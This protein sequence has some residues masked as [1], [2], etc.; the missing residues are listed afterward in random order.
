MGPFIDES[1]SKS[2]NQLARAISRPKLL[3]N[4]CRTYCGFPIIDA[5]TAVSEL[6][7]LLSQYR[8]N[9]AFFLGQ[10]PSFS[11]LLQP[12]GE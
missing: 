12:R 11:P 5:S 10:A 3:P 7:H 6:L 9:I 8:S 1:K 2:F 4:Y